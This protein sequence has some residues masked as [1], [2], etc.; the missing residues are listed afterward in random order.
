MAGSA[1]CTSSTTSTVGPRA[2]TRLSSA[3]TTIISIDGPLRRRGAQRREDQRRARHRLDH[4]GPLGVVR[5][6]QPSLQGEH[7]RV[8]HRLHG[9]EAQA[10]PPQHLRALTLTCSQT[11]RTRLVLPIPASPWTST[12]RGEP[13]RP[14]RTTSSSLARSSARPDS[15]GAK[16]AGLMT[17]SVTPREPDCL[18]TSPAGGAPVSEGPFPGSEGS[19]PIRDRWP[20]NQRG[21]ISNHHTRRIS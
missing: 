8:V 15:V 7:Q 16:A 19:L 20:Q 3:S 11:L 9:P 13:S 4:R 18:P 6:A 21:G 17:S 5:L 10:L 2:I 1:H 14:A 12:A